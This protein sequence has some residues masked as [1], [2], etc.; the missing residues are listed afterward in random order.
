MS[1]RFKFYDYTLTTDAQLLEDKNQ[2]PSELEWKMEKLYKKA[3]NGGESNIRYIKKA[4]EKYPHTPHLKNYLSVAY[5]NS[6]MEEESYKINDRIIK[7]HPQY[8][9]GILNKA[10]EYLNKGEHK[11]MPEL[12]GENM[13]L[14]DLFPER[15]VFHV[16]EMT[17]FLETAIQY[18]MAENNFEATK[19][20]VKILK[21]LDPENPLVLSFED[22][23]S[24]LGIGDDNAPF[25][26][27][28]LYPKPEFKSYDKSIQTE[29]S[30]T[31]QNEIIYK[32]Y[33]AGFD[34]AQG[35]FIEIMKLPRESVIPDLQ[36][37]LRDSV[38][39]YEYFRFQEEKGDVDESALCFPIHAT[40][41]LGEMKAGEAMD[42]ILETL[43]QGDEFLNFWYNDVLFEVFWQP[44]YKLLPENQETYKQFMFEPGIFTYAKSAISQTYLQYFLHNPGKREEIVAWYKEVLNTYL[45]NDDN[46]L[47]DG[48][49]IAFMVCDVLDAKFD[50]LLPL[51]EQLYDAD[52]VEEYIAGTKEEVLRDFGKV[53]PVSPKQPLL[54][55]FEQYDEI[56]NDWHFDEEDEDDEGDEDLRFRRLGCR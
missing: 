50:E 54:S 9:F 20:R 28:K 48:E 7:E 53:P 4:I 6:G 27:D 32:L 49:L 29:E 17:S 51:I 12:I 41:L 2:V 44:L 8:L 45:T 30:P 26:S 1:E 56:L 43:R 42:D 52:Y 36:K 22:T 18:F 23:L 3:H 5:M 33:E 34:I 24:I 15:E 55:I 31:F 10:N 13:E 14:R 38:C 39:R 47:V 46:N 25:E 11:R 37:V 16:A 21:E 35:I 19:S 40:F